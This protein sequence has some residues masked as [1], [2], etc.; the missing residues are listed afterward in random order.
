MLMG[1]LRCVKLV[2][3]YILFTF[4]QKIAITEKGTKNSTQRM[5]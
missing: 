2:S 1:L 4:T 3:F 5:N